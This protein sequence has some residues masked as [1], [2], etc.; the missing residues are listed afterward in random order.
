MSQAIKLQHRVEGVLTPKRSPNSARAGIFD[1]AS[2]AKLIALACSAPPE[3]RARW[4]LQLL[5]NQV[6]ALKI[7]ARVSDI[8][9]LLQNPKVLVG[10]DAEVV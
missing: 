4:T 5:E 2:E 6:I 1:G 9:P 3:G 10:Y 7:V 8:P